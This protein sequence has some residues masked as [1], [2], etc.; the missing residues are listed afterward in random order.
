M[1]AVNMYEAKATLSRLVERA[2]AGEEI[3][4]ARA[5]TPLV[6][7]VPV[8]MESKPLKRHSGQNDLGISYIAEDFDAPLPE[9][10]LERFGWLGC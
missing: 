5:G 9:D 8:Q 4:I 3:I 2:V 1:A 10:L 7:M 6:K